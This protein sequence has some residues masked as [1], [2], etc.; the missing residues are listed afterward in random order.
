[1]TA[2]RADEFDDEEFCSRCL[3]GVDSSEH[4]EK[5]VNPGYAEIG[6]SA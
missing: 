5:C 2:E 6:E 3:A 1:M 4:Y